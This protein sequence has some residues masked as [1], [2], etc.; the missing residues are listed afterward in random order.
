[1]KTPSMQRV[2]MPNANTINGVV[3]V[4]FKKDILYMCDEFS[5]NMAA[6]VINNK[7]N[8]TVIK[9]FN[10]KWVREGP[11]IPS[12]GIFTDNGGEFKNTELKEVAAKYGLSLST[13]SLV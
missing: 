2:A 6:E 9:A 13:F 3:S 4:D 10:K 1:M 5:G 12:K 11:G 7:H 8:E